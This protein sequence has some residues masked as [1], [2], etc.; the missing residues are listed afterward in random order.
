MGIEAAARCGLDFRTIA[1]SGPHL[2][3]I[4][5]RRRIEQLMDFFI[6]LRLLGILL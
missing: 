1:Y 4:A 6:F 3:G 5:G 2:Y